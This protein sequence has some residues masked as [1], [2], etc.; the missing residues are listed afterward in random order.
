MN[1]QQSRLLISGHCTPPSLPPSATWHENSP[2]PLARYSHPV[3]EAT[4]ESELA[5]LRRAI[6][7]LSDAQQ[8]V[9]DLLVTRDTH[10]LAAKKAGASW[11]EL[12]KAG[13]LSPGGLRKVL[14]RHDLL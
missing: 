8:T 11:T 3:A 4:K 12:Q 14:Q 6:E 1:P 13:D 5:A 10:I 2:I 7:A 9:S